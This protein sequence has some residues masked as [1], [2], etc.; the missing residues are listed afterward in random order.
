M[1]GWTDRDSFS[2]KEAIELMGRR[3]KSFSF[4]PLSKKRRNVKKC[5]LP[6]PKRHYAEIEGRER[7]R[8]TF[9]PISQLSLSPSLPLSRWDEESWC[10]HACVRAWARLR[11][12]VDCRANARE[13]EEEDMSVA[14]V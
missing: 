9:N 1:N 3:K 12:P 6:V 8:G 13:G 14:R 5:E 2:E 4:C 10:V 7:E 11:K